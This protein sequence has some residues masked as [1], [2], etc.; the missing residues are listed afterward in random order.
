MVSRKKGGEEKEKGEQD[1]KKA[2]REAWARDGGKKR[3]E[4]G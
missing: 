3:E 4:E 2:G 1:N